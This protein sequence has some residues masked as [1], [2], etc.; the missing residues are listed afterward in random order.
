MLNRSVVSDSVIPWTVSCQPPLS[1]GILQARKLEWAA[2]T[3]GLNPGLPHCRQIL[4]QWS[5]QGS[6]RILEWVA[7]PF[8]RGFSSPRNQTGVS[9]NVGRFF[10]FFFESLIWSFYCICILLSIWAYIFHSRKIGIIMPA[11]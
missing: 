1:M 5:Y 6:P 11:L 10:F 8:S 4:C 9:L 2:P 3:L 7:Y